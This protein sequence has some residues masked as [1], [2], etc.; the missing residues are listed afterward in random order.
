VPSTKFGVKIFYRVV[1]AFGLC[2]AVWPYLQPIL[3]INAGFLSSRYADKLFMVCDYD[4]EQQLLPLT[5]AVVAGEKSV[6]NWGWFMQWLRKEVVGPDKITVILDQHLGIRAVF[7][8]S[9]F[10]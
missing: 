7:E 3:T 6:A 8:I 2:I 5:F 9:N 10:G 4:A 1:W